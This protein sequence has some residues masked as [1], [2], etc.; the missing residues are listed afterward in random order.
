MAAIFCV[1][2]PCHAEFFAGLRAADIDVL[3]LEE[4]YVRPGFV[5]A[6][7]NGS[8]HHSPL[9]SCSPQAHAVSGGGDPDEGRAHALLQALYAIGQTIVTRVSI[10]LAGG[11]WHRS[12]TLAGEAVRWP[13]GWLRRARAAGG[14]D[15]LADSL[16]AGDMGPYRIVALQV[17]D[18]VN[19]TRNGDGRTT[20]E[21]V[22]ALTLAFARHAPPDEILVFK[23]HPLDVGH[24][25]Y[26][27]VV[28]A[29]AR[30][31]GVEERVGCLLTG[32]LGPLVRRSHG[33][34]T[35]NSTS[36]LS[37]LRHGL[38]TDV[39]GKAFYEGNGLARRVERLSEIWT[40]PFHPDERRVDALF[41]RMKA[42][43]L[44][45]GSFYGMGSSTRLSERIAAE[46]SA[47]LERRR[48]DPPR[49]GDA[50][51]SRSQHVMHMPRSPRL[52][53]PGAEMMGQVSCD[54]HHLLKEGVSLATGPTCRDSMMSSANDANAIMSSD[55]ARTVSIVS[56]VQS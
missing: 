41:A 54:H 47:R 17:H 40:H 35:V 37:G 22:D 34:V 21:M 7:W 5:S 2:R 8:H 48:D 16:M 36:G 32:A 9:R 10:P 51:T 45:P 56:V 43:S 4:G 25:D 18:D 27:G 31:H 44:L 29:A 33:L 1:D 38:Q 19:L 50:P 15:A 23:A 30:R 11:R 28:R 52:T 12:R 42:E 3:C 13:L 24:V 20:A 14:D 55:D 39:L 53:P 26:R 6:E 46:I 49:Q